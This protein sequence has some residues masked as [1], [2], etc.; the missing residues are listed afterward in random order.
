VHPRIFIERRELR[1]TRRQTVIGKNLLIFIVLSLFCTLLTLPASGEKSAP[2]R[3]E[4]PLGDGLI[5]TTGPKKGYIYMSAAPTGTIGAHAKGEWINNK[6]TFDLT[7]KATVDGS[8]NW[9]YSFDIEKVRDKRMFVGNLLPDH[10]TGTFP[11]RRSDDAYLYD[12]NPNKIQAGAVILTLPAN[13]TEATVPS[14]LPMGPI[15]I[16]TSGSVLFNAADERGN[17]AVAHEIQDACGGHPEVRGTYHY[18]HISDCFDHSQGDEHSPLIGYALDG[19]GIYGKY[20]EN[21]EQMTTEA[22]DEFHGH[23]HKIEWD[24]KR[25]EMYH[26]HATDE[27]P[28]TVGAFKGKPHYVSSNNVSECEALRPKRRPAVPPPPYET[29]CIP[30]PE[31]PTDTIAP[32]TPKGL[33][34]IAVT[35]TTVHFRWQPAKDDIGV[36]GYFIYRNGARVGDTEKTEYRLSGLLP[37]Q[38]YTLQVSAYDD[39]ENESGK[40]A[41]LA[42]TTAAKAK[43]PAT[44]DRSAPS[45]PGKLRAAQVGKDGFTVTWQASSDNVKVTGY[46]ILRDGKSVAEI[47]AGVTNYTLKGLKSDTRYRIQIK[48]KDGSNNRSAASDALIVTTLKK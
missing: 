31:D 2:K 41:P 42:V 43:A 48:A 19:F 12:R 15:G 10:A 24:G 38:K 16:L 20:G 21:G 17:D 37:K 18:H 28:Y 46:E 8:V 9:P 29:N 7:K 40:S 13:P 11:I 4:L 35:A 32:D 44:V 25:V 34:M 30:W 33:K 6:K 22:L 47:A 36:T 23:K 26:Y 14:P 39:A 5:S 45:K 27:F 1:V 3:T